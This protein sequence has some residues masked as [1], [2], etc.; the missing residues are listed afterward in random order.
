MTTTITTQSE[1]KRRTDLIENPSFVAKAIEAVKLMGI[2][3]EEFNN[4]R[5]A[6]LMLIANEF[7]SMEN[8]IN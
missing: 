3:S 7:C 2:S 4:N 8:K 5:M 1:L 6:I